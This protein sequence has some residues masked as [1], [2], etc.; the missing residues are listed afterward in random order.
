MPRKEALDYF[1]DWKSFTAINELANK[2]F[3]DGRFSMK[4]IPPKLRSIADE[5]LKS[6][7]IEQSVAPISI[8]AEDF[9]KNVTNKSRDKT[10]AAEVEH[11][12]RHYIDINLDDDPELFA[13]FSETLQ[14]IME[15][16]RGNWKRIYEELEKLREKIR[17]REKEETFG[18]DRKK[19]MPFFRIF[20]A[21]LFDNRKLNE[22]ENRN[23]NYFSTARLLR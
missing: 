17:N 2:H 19:Q 23:Q 1:N 3:R 15:E 5:F 18:L 7:G 16:F 20:K 13:S 21:E 12:I 11:A 6:V 14:Q 8:M 22:D 10:K 4:G 9:Q